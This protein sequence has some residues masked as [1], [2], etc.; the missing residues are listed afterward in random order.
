MNDNICIEPTLFQQIKNGDIMAYELFFRKYYLRLKTLAFRIIQDEDISN[1]LVQDIFL[2]LWENRTQIDETRSLKSWIFLSLRNN[3]LNY[4]RKQKTEQRYLDYVTF[5]NKSQELFLNNFLEENE[6]EALKNEMINEVLSIVN[7]LSPQC[8][9]VFEMSRFQRMKNKEIS[10]MLDI[11]VR[12]VEKHI[13]NAMMILS[14]K[15]RSKPFFVY[16]IFMMI[17]R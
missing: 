2:I 14:D 4:I 9:R 7:T 1:D 8:K 16:A 12:T 6:K 10:E 17:F 15:M 11:S 13:S 3:C 5:Q